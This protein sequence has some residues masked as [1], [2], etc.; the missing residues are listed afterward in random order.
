MANQSPG[1]QANSEKTAR[2][3]PYKEGRPRPQHTV[4][5]RRRRCNSIRIRPGERNYGRLLSPQIEYA[6]EV[7]THTLVVGRRT[8]RPNV[9]VTMYVPINLSLYQEWLRLTAELTAAIDEAVEQAT[10]LR[11]AMDRMQW[12]LDTHGT[13]DELQA[14]REELDGA[15]H[16]R[17]E[18]LERACYIN[19][20]IDVIKAIDH[21][22]ETC[23][24][25]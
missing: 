13:L 1:I 8:S 18:T 2:I 25:F 12:V 16:W 19:R 3:P 5:K 17:D 15:E 23:R 11:R 22:V 20:K 10:R 21:L 7:R 24:H 9:S 6:L 14:A 4:T